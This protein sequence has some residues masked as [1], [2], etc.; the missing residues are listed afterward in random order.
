V[1]LDGSWATLEA[2]DGAFFDADAKDN[3][4]Q[5]EVGGTDHTGIATKAVNTVRNEWF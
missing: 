4:G 5:F 2:G 1:L 3:F